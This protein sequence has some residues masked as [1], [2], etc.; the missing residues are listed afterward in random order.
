MTLLF[1]AATVRMRLVPPVTFT[2]QS[3]ELSVYGS[4]F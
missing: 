1:V 4:W 2:T 3:N